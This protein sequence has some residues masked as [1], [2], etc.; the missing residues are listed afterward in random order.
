MILVDFATAWHLKTFANKY[1]VLQK[2]TFHNTLLQH[3]LEVHF[4]FG[5]TLGAEMLQNGSQA[6]SSSSFFEIFLGCQVQFCLDD[7]L[8]WF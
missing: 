3:A 6:S 8:Q 5:P 7:V 2:H 4:G 1:E